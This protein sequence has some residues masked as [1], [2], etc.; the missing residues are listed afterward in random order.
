MR[1]D[2][3]ICLG[4]TVPETSAKYGVKVCMAGYS[5]E[6][7]S[8]LRVYPLE[9]QNPIHAR[10][11]CV[12]ELVRNPN[13]SR[14]ES[15]KLADRNESIVSVGREV[16]AS[17]ILGFLRDRISDSIE[18]LNARRESLGVL[19]LTSDCRGFFRTRNEVSSPDQG[20]LFD[21]ADM[22]KRFG[23]EALDIAPYI[24]FF[25]ACGKH[26]VL[27]I[28]EW[29]T[30]EWI[31]K[32]RGKA[33]QVWENLRLNDGTNTLAIVGNM[34]NYRTSWLVIKTFKAD[35]SNRAIGF[36]PFVGAIGDQ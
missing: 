22:D 18:E 19:E 14:A 17:G 8:F 26:H 35:R 23:A 6:L 12:L 2:D 13:D 36:L 32:H 25:D 33:A 15:W 11:S 4:R 5:P 24:E 20:L 29:G 31:R 10:S 30:Y 21:V 1:V 9:I 27:Q 34:S 7:R 3:F 28:R 16:K